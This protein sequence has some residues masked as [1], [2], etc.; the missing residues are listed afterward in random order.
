M[1]GLFS[2]RQRPLRLLFQ[3][4]I[5]LSLCAQSQALICLPTCPPT[6]A[7]DQGYRFQNPKKSSRPLFIDFNISKWETR[8]VFV[9]LTDD[10]EARKRNGA[11]INISKSP[12]VTETQS[13]KASCS[14]QPLS[15]VATS[16]HAWHNR[17]KYNWCQIKYLQC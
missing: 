11:F 8:G 13:S 15:A 17:N 16:P 14:K 12:R 9:I 10:A 6:L 2:S 3:D 4:R 7:A 5:Q 1:G